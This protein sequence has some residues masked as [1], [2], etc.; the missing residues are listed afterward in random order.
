MLILIFDTETTGLVPKMTILQKDSLGKYPH[1]VQFSYIIYDTEL[2][3]IIKIVDKIIRL[4]ETL[5]ISQVCVKLHG[6]SREIS[7]EKGVD[8]SPVIAEFF[9]DV[10]TTELLV[11]HNYEFDWVMIQVECLR[12]GIEIPHIPVE[13][14]CTMKETTAFCKIPSQFK[15]TEFKW[16]T[17][18]ELYVKLFN[19]VPE[20][21]HNSLFDV[22]A[23]LRCLMKFR[24]DI[25]IKNV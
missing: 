23:T 19:E 17:L 16:P 25:D 14:Y 7:T 2:N 8:I 22:Q 20:N 21:L 11:A 4:D 13:T 12:N 18:F 1:I 6:I 9:D 24:F 5:P 3:K 15:K 10:L